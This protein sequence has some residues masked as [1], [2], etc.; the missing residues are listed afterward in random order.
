MP[1]SDLGR[2]EQRS[3][4]PEDVAYFNTANLSPQLH[5]VRAAGHAALDRRGSPW[6]I[7]ADDWFSGVE[8]LRYLFGALVATDAEGIALVP[9]TS[10]GFA[11]AARKLPLAAGD[12]VLV[13]PEEYPSGIYTW[14]A[15]TRAAGAEMVKVRRVHGQSWTDA[16]L[17]AM[18]ER[19]SIVRVPN[20]RWTDGVR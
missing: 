16:I 10:Y 4:S 14:R 17:L 18:E 15:A 13:L 7:T 11:V 5:G 8:P 9:A 20:V 3:P 2:S 1:R 6:T 12:R 19:V